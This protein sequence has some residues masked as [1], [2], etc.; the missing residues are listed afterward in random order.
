MLLLFDFPA[1]F[2]ISS[3]MSLSIIKLLLIALIIMMLFG[4]GRLPSVM[5][6]LG[7]ALRSFK[8]G[9]KDDEEEAKKEAAPK[10]VTQDVEK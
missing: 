4:A 9:L 8:Q 5:G 7:K 1:G 6:D 3:D 10:M 2:A